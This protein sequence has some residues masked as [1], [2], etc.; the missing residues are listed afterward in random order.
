MYYRNNAIISCVVYKIIEQI[1]FLGI[2]DKIVD[3]LA[4]LKNSM[5]EVV[6]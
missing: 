1:G 4:K 6:N 2:K 3:K 5:I